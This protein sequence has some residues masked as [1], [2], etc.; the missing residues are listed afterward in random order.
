MSIEDDLK[1][2][3]PQQRLQLVRFANRLRRHQPAAHT[4]IITRRPGLRE[5]RLV[6]DYEL[7][8]FVDKRRNVRDMDC[9]YSSIRKHTFRPRPYGGEEDPYPVVHP[10]L[11][12]IQSARLVA[13]EE[14]EAVGYGFGR[15]DKVTQRSYLDFLAKHLMFFVKKDYLSVTTVNAGEMETNQAYY[16]RLYMSYQ[17]TTG[18][19]MY[20]RDVRPTMTL[21]HRV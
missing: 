5:A 16:Y 8:V 11:A 14:A 17:L 2:L 1:T 20:N 15:E 6:T 7:I 4:L 9:D 13:R 21:Q 10:G 18:Y 12:Y 19:V 3:T